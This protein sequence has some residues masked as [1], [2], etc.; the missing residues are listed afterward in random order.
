MGVVA[1]AADLRHWRA[2]GWGCSARIIAVS[3]QG[4]TG[5]GCWSSARMAVSEI[6]R[7]R[8]TGPRG[9]G[10]STGKLLARRGG[11]SS[12]DR[13]SLPHAVAS[14]SDPSNAVSPRRR[15]R[16]PAMRAAGRARGDRR[17]RCTRLRSSSCSAHAWLSLMRYVQAIEAGEPARAWRC[18][19]LHAVL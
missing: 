6:C 2:C 12:H 19:G 17:D 13:C 16:R 11:F 8:S 14:T 4:S 15:R 3:D 5:R 10:C 7:M 9:W 18:A 1:H